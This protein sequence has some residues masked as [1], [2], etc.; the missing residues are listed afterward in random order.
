MVAEALGLSRLLE[1]PVVDCVSLA[2]LVTSQGEVRMY[3]YFRRVA[4]NHT[5]GLNMTIDWFVD[6]YQP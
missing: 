2:V 4:G 6:S 3:S 5:E 1:V